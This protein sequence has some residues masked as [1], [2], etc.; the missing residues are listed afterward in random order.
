MNKIVLA[1]SLAVVGVLVGYQLGQ[2]PGAEPLPTPQVVAEAHADQVEVSAPAEAKVASAS[3]SSIPANTVEAALARIQKV[4][5]DIQFGPVKES[6]LEGFIKTSIVEGPPIYVT[7][8]GSYF[9]AGSIYE[10]GDTEIVDLAE[11]ELEQERKV[12]M[13]SLR[14]EDMIV[15]SPEGEVKS[16]VYVFTDV[17]CYYCQKLH[18]E[19]DEINA[20][21]IEVRYLAYPRKGIGSD[22]YRKIASAWCADDPNE[23][24]TD[25]KAGRSIDDNVCQPNPVAAQYDLGGRV[26]VRGT[27][28]MVTEDG[29]LMPG[30][31]PAATLAGMLG[32]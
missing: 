3:E 30:Y 18:A 24:L 12:Q 19:I 1:I 10:V 29:R 27:P 2:A 17:D 21:G 26:G 4:R 14:P 5:P 20:L 22:T 16:A 13:A 23:A 25:L 15:F 7:L 8:D 11:R 6:E 9:I 32:I 31:R 28:A